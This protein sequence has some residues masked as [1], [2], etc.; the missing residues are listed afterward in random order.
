MSDPT[1]TLTTFDLVTRVAKEAGLAFYG[2]AG[3]DPAMAPIDEHDL[4]LCLGIVNRGIM[5]FQADAPPNGWNWRKQLMYTKLAPAITGTATA[6][7]STSLT[8]GAWKAIAPA[9]VGTYV[10]NYFNGYTLWITSGTGLNATAVVTGYTSSTGKFDFSGGMSDGSTPTTSTVFSISRSTQVVH[11]ESS[12]YLMPTGFNGV[13]EGR[14]IY[15]RNT[16]HSTI[17]NW[18][19]ESEI[20]QRRSVVELLGYP[21]WASLRPL[22]SSDSTTYQLSRRQWELIVNPRPVKDDTLVFPYTVYF[23]RLDLVTGKATAVGGATTLVDSAR[24]EAD[25][26]FNGW[27]I[28]IMSGTGKSSYGVVTNYTGSSGTFEVGDWLGG[29]ADPT[30]NS[31]YYVDPVSNTHPAGLQHD[32]AVLSAC[33]ARMCLEVPDMDQKWAEKYYQ[34]DLKQAYLVDQRSAPRTLGRLSYGPRPHPSRTWKDV[35]TQHDIQF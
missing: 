29:S 35:T 2:L 26:Y 17:I 14:I 32:N 31:I 12:R 7:T 23:D 11:G 30:T 4:D 19:D 22:S 8:C 24:T 5:M 15:D 1:G 18:V 16:R 25:D 13:A 33:L 9:I 3:T 28:H 6:G 27:T 20:R 34:R 21:L 10:D